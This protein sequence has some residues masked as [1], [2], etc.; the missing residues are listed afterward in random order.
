VNIN[1]LQEIPAFAEMTVEMHLRIGGGKE[2]LSIKYI[3]ERNIPLN[4][5]AREETT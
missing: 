3:L 5:L 1:L 2:V 4:L